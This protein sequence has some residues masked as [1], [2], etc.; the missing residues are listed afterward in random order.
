MNKNEFV[1]VANV[2]EV[3]TGKLKHVEV[4][5]KEIVIANADGKFYALCDRCS[6][7]NAPLSDGSLK[8][9]TPL[10]GA[11]FDVTTGKKISDPVSLDMSALEKNIGPLPERWHTMMKHSA[12][13]VAKIKTYGQPIYETKIDED[14]I[15]VRV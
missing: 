9:N 3:P 1:E 13:L 12:Q 10:H 15:K 5:D 8:K 14:K 7:S 2:D 6:H 11:K 4:G